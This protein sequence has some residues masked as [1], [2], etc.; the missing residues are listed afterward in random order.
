MGAGETRPDEI[1]ATT[2][3][4]GFAEFSDMLADLGAEPAV[5]PESPPASENAFD[6]KDVT[7]LELQK[8]LA[9]L[10][11][12]GERLGE[13]EAK[14]LELEA[15]LAASERA[16]IANS[17]RS[18]ETMRVLAEDMREET[19]RLRKQLARAEALL[20]TTRAKLD[21]RKRVA[22]ERWSE[23]RALRGERARLRRELD[24][25]G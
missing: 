16:L 1:G 22:A 8:A 12:L 3:V 19:T 6:L 15:Q 11:P 13:S 10:Q 18:R 2:R 4:D 20:E 25:R 5:A 23:I 21:E 14:R 9:L 7:I 17:E 24:G